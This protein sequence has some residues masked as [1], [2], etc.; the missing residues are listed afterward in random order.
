MTEG[1]F[2]TI[3]VENGIPLHYSDHLA[4][5]QRECA[6][7]SLDAVLPTLDEIMT[8]INSEKANRGIW[9]LRIAVDGT[10]RHLSIQPY[11]QVNQ[12]YRIAIYPEPWPNLK[13]KT[14]SFLNRSILLAWAHENGYDEVL[15]TDADGYV[16]EGAFCNVFW[17]EEE[18]L[19]FVDPSLPYYEGSTQERVIR[20]SKKEI[21]FVRIKPNE[22]QG[23]R[24]Y[25]CNTL[26]GIV[27][28]ALFDSLSH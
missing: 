15:T 20:E 25:L 17:E 5:L 26:M 14:L 28:V 3:R 19:C 24:L 6:S 13:V 23:K 27:P 16:L 10:N 4:R 18:A 21:R 22:L 9:R 8:F 7:V 11:E 12:L 2:R 1:L